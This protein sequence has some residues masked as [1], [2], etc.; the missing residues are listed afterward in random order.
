MLGYVNNTARNLYIMVSIKQSS[1]ILLNLIKQQETRYSTD[2]Q[3]V[4]NEVLC[5]CC[6]ISTLELV[7]MVIGNSIQKFKQT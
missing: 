1:A 4:N 5:H 6:F 2:L 3:S 7:L